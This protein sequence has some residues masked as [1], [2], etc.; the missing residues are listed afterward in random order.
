[1]ETRDLGRTGLRVTAIGFGSQTVGGLGYGDQDWSQSQP[2]VERY[3][4]GGGRFIDSARGYGTSEIHVGKAIKAVGLPADAVVVCSKSGSLHPPC[5]AAD[6]DVSRFCLQRDW[7]DVYYVH[8]PSPDRAV[9]EKILDAYCGFK[10][11]GYIRCVGLSCRDVNDPAHQDE[12]RGW[13]RDARVDAIQFP[14]NF[15][16]PHVGELI[17]DAAAH[18]KGAVCRG[19]VLSGALD[20]R[21]LPGHR[22]TDRDN[23]WRAQ[24]EPSAMDE[25]LAIVQEI[26]RKHVRPPYR[27][28]SQL[29]QLWVLSH[30][31]VS[32]I[33]PGAGTVAEM[34]LV[35]ALDGLPPLDQATRDD[36]AALAAPLRELLKRRGKKERRPPQARKR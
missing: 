32:A 4:R 21:L 34:D 15:S 35:L 22:F 3:L 27:S 25:A 36:L 6:L 19:T 26:K 18:G 20:D 28:V 1:M 13:I 7:I 14:F 24:V 5:T 10:R 23:D 11:K 8:V 29:S 31:S 33:I 9:H 17:A 16:V 30:P 12:I 2:T